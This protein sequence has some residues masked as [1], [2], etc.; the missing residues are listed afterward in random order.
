[1]GWLDWVLIWVPLLI[2]VYFGMKSQKYV[3]SVAD[4]LSAG[5]I[6]GRYLICVAGAEAGQGLIS[7]VATMEMYYRSGFAMS[8]WSTLTAPISM[9]GQRSLRQSA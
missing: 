6:A 5:R 4:F 7:V 1:M 3:K 8:F 9:I 2:V